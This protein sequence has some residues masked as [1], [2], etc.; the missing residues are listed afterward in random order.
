MVD[1]VLELSDRDE[2]VALATTMKES[3]QA[4]IEVL[5]NLLTKLGARPL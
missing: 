4:E 1:G 5:R 3:Q 2:V